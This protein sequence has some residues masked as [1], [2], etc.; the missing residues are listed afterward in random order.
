LRNA[1]YAI[2]DRPNYDCQLGEVDEDIEKEEYSLPK[3]RDCSILWKLRE[4][5]KSM[6]PLN[7]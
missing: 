4:T 2:D 5:T 7:F 1:S 3:G 6:D